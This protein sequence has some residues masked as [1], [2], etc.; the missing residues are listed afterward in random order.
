MIV[1]PSATDLSIPSRRNLQAA[2]MISPLPI[3][4]QVGVAYPGPAQIWNRQMTASSRNELVKIVDTD[5]LHISP[6]RNEGVIS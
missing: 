3:S 1:L 5:D 4:A 6:L 2:S